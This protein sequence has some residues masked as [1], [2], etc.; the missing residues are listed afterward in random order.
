MEARAILS[1]GYGTAGVLRKE[2]H[3]DAQLLQV[4][5]DIAVP[6]PRGDVCIFLYWY[7]II[8]GSEITNDQAQMQL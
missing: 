7:P 5:A 8:S 2:E 6:T 4:V 1:V 3:H